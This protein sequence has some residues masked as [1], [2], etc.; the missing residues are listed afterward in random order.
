MP[1]ISHGPTCLCRHQT[2]EVL[3]LRQAETIYPYV[4]FGEFF[5]RPEP[6]HAGMILCNFIFRRHQMCEF[7]VSLQH[8]S[9]CPFE[10]FG[11]P[12][13]YAELC[14]GVVYAAACYPQPL[15]H[16][17]WCALNMEN[18]S[19]W[20]IREARLLWR[21]LEFLELTSFLTFCVKNL[22]CLLDQIGLDWFN[23]VWDVKMSQTEQECRSFFSLRPQILQPHAE[24]ST[25]CRHRT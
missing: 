21:K 17:Q 5:G 15:P 3:V 14:K 8:E 18:I 25:Y 19:N 24:D 4:C 12:G 11:G 7:L 16:G 2:W 9:I 6:I 23:C 1:K 20:C 10:C 22:G 13:P